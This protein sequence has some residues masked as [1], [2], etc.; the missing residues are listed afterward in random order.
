MKILCIGD[1]HF[2]ENLAYADYISDR[3]I[4]E[5]K[6]VLN[7]IVKS[8]ED[9]GHIVFMGDNFNSK[10]N[11]SETNRE[12]VEFIEKFG[13]KEIYILSG[14]HEK[15]GDGKTAIDFLGEIKKKNWH[16][17]TKPSS[18]EV[19]GL[20][21]DFLPY[22]LNSELGVETHAEATE[23]IMGHLDGGGI[24]FAHH[25]ITGTTWN[26]IKTE[27]FKEVVLPREA[28]EKKYKLTI[29]GHVHDPQQVGS[30]I[31][32]G[33][34]FTSE[35]GEKEKFIWKIDD[36]LN[37][38]Q[39]KLPCRPISK[40][41][42]DQSDNGFFELIDLPSKSIVKVIVTDKSVLL[43]EVKEVLKRF[44]ASLL[45]ESYPS[46]RK[47]AN[48]EDGVAFDFSIEALLKL[49]AEEKGIDVN[50]LMSGLSIINNG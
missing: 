41:I 29:A 9:C 44:D 6:E 36:K 30:T 12:F 4:G 8:A 15:K 14:N 5:K 45:I 46:E 23:H 47:K 10:N 48:I 31:I 2:K 7:L 37:I 34:V 43:D 50:Q 28:L 39:I 18:V 24:L 32:T 49:Y 38:E 22:M 11:S 16:I 3:R 35:V 13:D 1:Q 33:S 25:A 42:L 17:F 40:V 27:M 21:L 26:G 20:K 19:E